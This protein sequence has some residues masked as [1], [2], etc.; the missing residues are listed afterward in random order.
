MVPEGSGRGKWSTL[1]FADAYRGLFGL[2]R[3]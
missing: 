2:E 3:E 1:G